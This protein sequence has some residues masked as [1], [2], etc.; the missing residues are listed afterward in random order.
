M[1]AWA[2]HEQTFLNN[3]GSL[4]QENAAARVGL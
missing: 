2:P 4:W 1:S 3:V